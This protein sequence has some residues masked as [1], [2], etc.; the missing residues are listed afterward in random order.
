MKQT[1][2]LS[3]LVFLAACSAPS[4]PDISIS[5]AKIKAPL[6]GQTVAMGTLTINN[7]GAADRLL[8]VTTPLTDRAE[9]HTHIT[10]AGGVM[11]MRRVESLAVP[12]RGTLVL[13]PGGDHIMLF[14]AQMPSS[15]NMSLTL[16]FETSGAITVDASL[17]K[18]GGHMHH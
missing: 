4:T 2:A 8:S 9:L 17:A 13:K 6:P 11:K 5:N 3:A 12:A 1:L 16:N 15:G 14:D 7:E 10:D 18:A